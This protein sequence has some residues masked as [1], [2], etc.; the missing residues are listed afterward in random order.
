VQKRQLLAV[1]N[2]KLKKEEFEVEERQRC[3]RERHLRALQ[4]AHAEK[5]TSL[6][7]RNATIEENRK[8]A[9]HQRKKDNQR[10]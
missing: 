8:A 10:M 9:D 6:A 7:E 3:E 5:E 1:E 2:L 4:L